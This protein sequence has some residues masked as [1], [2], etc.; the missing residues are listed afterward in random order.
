MQQLQHKQ[1]KM[2]NELSSLPI[3]YCYVL[4][5]T[6]LAAIGIMIN[7]DKQRPWIER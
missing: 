3:R 6:G 5:T 1:F 7:D 4:A 2:W